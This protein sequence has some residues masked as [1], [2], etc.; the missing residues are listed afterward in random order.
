MYALPKVT[1]QECSQFS[2]IVCYR[3]ISVFPKLVSIVRSNP[4]KTDVVLEADNGWS[5]QEF[6]VHIRK[7][8]YCHVDC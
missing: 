5:L 8:A 4:N 2:S 1:Y 3:M 6:E 7:R